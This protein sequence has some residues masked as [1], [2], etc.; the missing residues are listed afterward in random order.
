MCVSMPCEG[1]DMDAA[2]DVKIEVG[3]GPEGITCWG[4]G[5]TRAASGPYATEI[6][7][8]PGGRLIEFWSI[9]NRF[10]LKYQLGARPNEHGAVRFAYV[11]CVSKFYAQGL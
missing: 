11:L 5:G 8:S 1:M 10:L 3:T 2:V 4:L 6:A 7:I 9:G